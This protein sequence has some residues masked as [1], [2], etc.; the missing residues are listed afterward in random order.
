MEFTEKVDVTLDV[1]NLLQAESWNESNTS[2]HTPDALVGV[3]TEN[4]DNPHGLELPRVQ[5]AHIQ[6]TP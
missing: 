2:A 1:E 4:I 3:N 6:R 5:I